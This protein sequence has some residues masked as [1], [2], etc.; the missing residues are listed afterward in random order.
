MLNCAVFQHKRQNMYE[1]IKDMFGLYY[2]VKYIRPTYRLLLNKKTNLIELHDDNY[3]GVNMIFTPPIT[4]DILEKINKT[5][6]ENSN[7]LFIEIENKNRILE[8]KQVENAIY[9]AKN[10]INNS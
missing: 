4:A 7:K 8:E 6:M 10:M 9:F 1:E 3:R 2:R 5:K